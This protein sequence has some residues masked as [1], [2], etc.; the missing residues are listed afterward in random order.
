MATVF[1]TIIVRYLCLFLLLLSLLILFL[2]FI[3]LSVK[4]PVLCK[5]NPVN[6]Q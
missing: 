1:T 4:H 5:V 6:L 2:L 3:Y